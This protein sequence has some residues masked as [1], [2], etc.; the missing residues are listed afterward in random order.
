MAGE[1]VTLEERMKGTAAAGRVH[2]KTGYVNHSSAL[3]G[4]ATTVRGE[5]LVFSMFG[6]FIGTRGRDA[7][8]ALDAM[9]VAMV[10][11]LGP[12]DRRRGKPRKPRRNKAAVGRIV[13][14]SIVSRGSYSAVRAQPMVAE[15]KGSSRSFGSARVRDGEPDYEV[16]RLL[17][18]ALAARGFAVCTGGYG[19]VMEAASRGAKE[20]GGRT[21]AVTAK[22]FGGKANAWIDRE[23]A[24]QGWEERLFELIR[25]RRWVRG[26]QGR[27]RNAGGAGGGVGNAEQGHRHRE[28]V[29]GAG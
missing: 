26:V 16:A 20:A 29:R 2:A 14:L 7:T 13:D 17:G 27:D 18:H 5:R 10:E 25:L 11:E 22:Y 3:S 6:N 4:Y 28:T 19:G 1:D 12:A 24:V 9:C 23:Q 15:S 8:A 21:I